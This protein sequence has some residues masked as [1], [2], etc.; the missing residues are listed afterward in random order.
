MSDPRII[1]KGT[2]YEPEPEHK[3]IVGADPGRVE[4]AQALFVECLRRYRVD[5]QTGEPR[6]IGD[7]VRMALITL[8]QNGFTREEILVAMS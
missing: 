2:G 1:I 8:K 3:I 4:K 5:S 6:K 7:V